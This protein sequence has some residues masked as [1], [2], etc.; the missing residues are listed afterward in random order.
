MSRAATAAPR[1]HLEAPAAMPTG[2]APFALAVLAQLAVLAPGPSGAAEQGAGRAGRAARAGCPCLDVRQTVADLSPYVDCELDESGTNCTDTLRSPALVRPGAESYL[3]P[4]DYGRGACAQWDAAL[5]PD[6]AHTNGTALLDSPDWCRQPWCYV[7]PESCDQADVTLT[8][9]FAGISL[10]YS[11]S[12]CSGT[13]KFSSWLTM[14]AC[15]TAPSSSKDCSELKRDFGFKDKLGSRSICGTSPSPCTPDATFV[16]AVAMCLQSGSRLCSLD[17]L[18]A[19]EVGGT[20]CGFDASNMW[21]SSRGACAAGEFMITAGSS[22]NAVPVPLG[23]GLPSCSPV[24]ARNGVR[25]CG[26]EATTQ[27]ACP[28][29]ILTCAELGWPVVN[30]EEFAGGFCPGAG[31]VYSCVGDARHC[32]DSLTRPCTSVELAALPAAPSSPITAQL[33]MGH[34]ETDRCMCCADS[35]VLADPCT[36]PLVLSATENVQQY[37]SLEIQTDS[38]KWC[39]WI[40]EG[41]PS[42]HGVQLGFSDV[43]HHGAVAGDGIEVYAAPSSP[44]DLATVAERLFMITPHMMAEIHETDARTFRRNRDGEILQPHGEPFRE[45]ELDGTLLVTSPTPAVVLELKNLAKGADPAFE[46]ARA[47]F[48]L[49]YSCVPRGNG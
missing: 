42:T 47:S 9:F 2:T 28:G 10:H 17:E 15:D 49:G 21:S 45:R 4:F 36:R 43:R 14:E 32:Y 11:Y 48:A 22:Y 23:T 5:P 37:R 8:G 19:N 29:S 46:D 7:D 40:I 16:E 18:L 38:W 35:A 44:V 1:D 27:P 26:D 33:L 12:T 34:S 24:S 41:C 3:Y 25:C 31:T 30:P 6:C 39:T 13:N 20:G